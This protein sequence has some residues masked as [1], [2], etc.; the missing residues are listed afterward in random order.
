MQSSWEARPASSRHLP[1]LDGWRALS[2]AFVL[3][4]HLLPLG[5]GS[6][7]LNAPV[8][9]TGMVIFFTLSGFLITRFLIE[10]GDIR[11]FLVR[12]LLRI[13]PLAWLGMLL[14][15][16]VSGGAS[17][18][19]II[20][21]LLF[22]ANLPPS[23]LIPPGAHFWSL[24]IEVQFYLTIALLV[25]IG[26]RRS[27]LL[28]PLLCVAITVARIYWQ[29]PM[30]IVTWFRI[31]EI[32]A[33][34]TLA[35]IYEGWL[36]ERVRRLV[37]MPSPL[38]IF[39]LLLASADLRTGFLPYLRPY[40]S[41]LMVGASLY[42]APRWLHE[43]CQKRVVTYV[44]QT[45]YALYVFHGIFANSWLGAG[46]TLIKYLK[47]PLLI[48]VTVACAHLS[49]F[50]YERRWISLGRRLTARTPQTPLDGATGPDAIT[51]EGRIG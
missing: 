23:T 45:S 19:Q 33:G 1:L 44:A 40:L 29:Q 41:A 32:L 2:I 21:N 43:L 30:S 46:D 9:A 15:F 22:A 25:A 5:P 16:A 31:D 18:D 3:A 10:D 11:R 26:G 39:P 49:T 34:A 8:A 7:R 28:I 51:V 37:A 35:L 42:N 20:G 14:A 17:M 13:V 50:H 27:L 47:R 48:A 38:L 12:R 36:G 6:W 4:G 24:C